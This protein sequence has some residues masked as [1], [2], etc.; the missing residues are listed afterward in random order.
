MND[1]EKQNAVQLW[2]MAMKSLQVM[3]M[4][5]KCLTEKPKKERA[6]DFVEM[7]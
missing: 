2:Q 3:Y 1:I 4:F 5:Q 6:C 7:T